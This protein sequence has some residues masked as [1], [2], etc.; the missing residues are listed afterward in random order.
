MVYV[1]DTY[2]SPA[3][4]WAELFSPHSHRSVR[5]TPL[6]HLFI[7]L[8]LHGTD[9]QFL[10]DAF[11]DGYYTY[12]AAD[13]FSYGATSSNWAELSRWAKEDGKIFIPCIGPG[14]DDTRIRPW[15]GANKRARRS[16]AYYRQMFSA[17]QRTDAQILGLTSYNEWGEGTQLEAAVAFT[18]EK[19]EKLQEYEA[20]PSMYM[21]LTREI[22][23]EFKAARTTQDTRDGL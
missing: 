15:N 21:D 8:V 6:D 12:F 13:G 14:Y 7:A 3:S 18:T 5:G 9:R 19:G 10:R 4:E 20:G 16:G 23:A 2:L 1:Y 17:A 11:A 22:A